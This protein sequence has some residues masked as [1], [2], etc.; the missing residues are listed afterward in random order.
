MAIPSSEESRTLGLWSLAASAEFAASPSA[1][2]SQMGR[3]A[4]VPP[5]SNSVLDRLGSR[6]RLWD[7]E[8]GGL[9]EGRARL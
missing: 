9:G 3:N 4:I 8:L 6:R 1:Q 5:S 7:M 2:Q